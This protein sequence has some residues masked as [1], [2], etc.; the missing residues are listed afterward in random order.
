M[1]R[2]KNANGNVGPVLQFEHIERRESGKYQIDI[3]VL[4]MLE[5][6]PEYVAEQTG[7]KPPVDQ[8]VEKALEQVLNSDAG[9]KKFLNCGNGKGTV[10]GVKPADDATPTNGKSAAQAA[11]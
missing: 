11:R 8:V 2:G 6:Y 7:H 1:A 10:K 5:K 3:R 4:D 9:F